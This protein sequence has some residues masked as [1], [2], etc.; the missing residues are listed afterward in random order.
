[1]MNDMDKALIA[2]L[3]QRVEVAYQEGQDRLILKAGAVERLLSLAQRLPTPV[4][5]TEGQ[6]L[7]MWRATNKDVHQ[8]DILNSDLTMF[9]RVLLRAAAARSESMEKDFQR[10]QCIVNCTNLQ[11]LDRLA[12]A[13]GDRERMDSLTDE[14][15]TP[16]QEV[17]A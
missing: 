7:E 3:T 17:S 2:D 5:L 9:A 8:G 6:V 10:Y 14:L 13:V 4:N 15:M 12:E 11:A 1:M 16:K